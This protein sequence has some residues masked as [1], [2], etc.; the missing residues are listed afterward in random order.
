MTSNIL[1]QLTS[2]PTNE[3]TEL[4]PD[5][6]SGRKNYKDFKVV[7]NGAV[8]SAASVKSFKW[9]SSCDTSQMNLKKDLQEAKDAVKTNVNER[10]ENA[11]NQ[12]QN[13]KNNVNNIIETKKNQVDSLK[14]DINQIKT[15]IQQAK[16]NSKQNSENLK[17]LLKNAVKN[18]G[19]KMPETPEPEQ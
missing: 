19:Q 17:N 10:I 16:E 3:N 11:K 2:D 13:V 8:E 6:T 5:L 12:A 1:K 7:F 9:L 18:A 4:I 15:D 14:K